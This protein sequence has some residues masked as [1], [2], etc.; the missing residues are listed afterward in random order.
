MAF[1]YKHVFWDPSRKRGDLI[2]CV[3][4]IFT[5]DLLFLCKHGGAQMEPKL[6]LIRPVQGPLIQTH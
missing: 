6:G 5:P 2:H 3:A 1:W 4:L